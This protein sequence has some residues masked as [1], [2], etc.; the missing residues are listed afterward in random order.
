MNKSIEIFLD[1]LLDFQ[2]RSDT[3][4][5]V[6]DY[7]KYNALKVLYH[8]ITKISTEFWKQKSLELFSFT[9]SFFEVHS[10]K[11]HQVVPQR[12]LFYSPESI[13]FR[14]ST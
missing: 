13:R 12:T 8:T 4:T 14:R 5:D 2:T 1:M 7:R 6:L 10:Y 3:A 11:F 9:F